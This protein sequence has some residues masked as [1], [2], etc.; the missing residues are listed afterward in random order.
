[1]K[2]LQSYD[3]GMGV[4]DLQSYEFSGGVWIRRDSTVNGERINGLFHLL[5][6]GAKIGVI[7]HKFLKL[8]PNLLEHPSKP[9]FLGD[10]KLV[11]GFNPFEKY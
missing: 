7:T 1:M 3:L 9:T 4:I 5:I 6:K 2:Y 11:G 8:D 10:P